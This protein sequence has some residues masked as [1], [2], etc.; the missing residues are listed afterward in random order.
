ML[1]EMSFCFEDEFYF[2]LCVLMI[3]NLLFSLEIRENN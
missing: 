3:Y 2:Y 1:Y